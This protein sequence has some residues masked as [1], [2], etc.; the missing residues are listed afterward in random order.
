MERRRGNEGAVEEILLAGL[1]SSPHSP[2]LN[3]SL[4][5]LRIRQQRNDEALPLL[6]RAWEL[7]PDTARFGYVYAIAL[8]SEGN[9]TGALKVL[10]ELHERAPNDPEVLHALVTFNVPLGRLEDA[11]RYAQLLLELDPENERVR[12][13]VE[14]LSA[15]D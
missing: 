6:K 11:Y 3:H 2:G 4:A 12:Q 15:E 7:S 1:E 10:E 8:N 14:G 13:L 5:L 9:A